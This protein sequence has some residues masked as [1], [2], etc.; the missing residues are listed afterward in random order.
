LFL[1]VFFCFF[2]AGFTPV[3]CFALA[4]AS[5]LFLLSAALFAPQAAVNNHFF[6]WERQK[7]HVTCQNN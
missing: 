2:E 5:G 7:Q 4:L 3:W 6:P 1:F